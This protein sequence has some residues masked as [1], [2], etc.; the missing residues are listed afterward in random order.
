MKTNNNTSPR[1]ILFGCEGTSLTPVERTFFERIQPLGFILFR[2]NCKTPQQIRSLISELK[3]C[4][5]HEQVPILIDQEGGCVARLASPHWREYPEAS[6]FGKIADHDMDLAC[7]AVETN[8]FLIGAELQELGITVNCAPVLD[9]SFFYGHQIIGSRSFHEAPEICSTL[10]YH[11]LKGFYKS[12]IIPV[13]KHL[14]GHGRALLDS[15]EDLPCIREPLEELHE[16]D[17]SAFRNLV[18]HV[19]EA[20]DPYPWGMTAHI[21]YETI[22]PQKP[23]TLSE[24]IIDKIIRQNIGFKGF[25]IS[26]CLTMKA[27]SGDMSDNALQAIQSGCDAVLHC[28]GNLNEMIDVSAKIPELSLKSQD[29]LRRS[30]VSRHFYQQE[31]IDRLWVDFNYHLKGYWGAEQRMI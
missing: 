26:D 1:A 21:V 28:S 25:L 23:A 16:T 8:T 17:F 14:P 2:R 20:S 18:D 3:S 4:V 13:I 10:G 22:D 9:L 19:E 12:G 11:A 27:L 15:H 5:T 29:R 6:L 24:K 7:W 31:T 30:M